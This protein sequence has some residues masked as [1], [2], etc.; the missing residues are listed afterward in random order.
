M[1]DSRRKSN[2]AGEKR[3]KWEAMKIGYSHVLHLR[4]VASD[5]RTFG[6]CPADTSQVKGRAR[7]V[8]LSNREGTLSRRTPPRKHTALPPEA[9]TRR[10]KK[11]VCWVEKKKGRTHSARNV[12]RRRRRTV[13]APFESFMRFAPIGGA[14]Y[15]HGAL[16]IFTMRLRLCAGAVQ[17]DL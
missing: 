12:P 2:K 11:W 8:I 16:C 1:A 15:S 13:V 4:E 3:G 6:T 9:T 14:F 7:R 17:R 5:C 10:R